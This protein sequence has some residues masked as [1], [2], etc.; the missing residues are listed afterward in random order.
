[1]ECR[2]IHLGLMY[3]KFCLEC[4]IYFPLLCNDSHYI[5][6]SENAVEVF[7]SMQISF[8]PLHAYDYTGG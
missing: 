5:I 7:N 1:M 2:I 3:H 4:C 8:M 6:A